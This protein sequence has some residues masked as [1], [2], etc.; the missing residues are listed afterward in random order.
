M[1]VGVWRAVLGVWLSHNR[2]DSDEERRVDC[3]K[4]GSEESEARGERAREGAGNEVRR[5][6]SV[7]IFW[8]KV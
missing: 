3:G 8:T 4:R 1:G 5:L 6:F 7:L 2:L